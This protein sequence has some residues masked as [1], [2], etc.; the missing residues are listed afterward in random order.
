VAAVRPSRN[1][2][3]G[4]LRMT[5]DNRPR[6]RRSTRRAATGSS[7]ESSCRPGEPQRTLR[8]HY[9]EVAGE[10]A[11]CR[12]VRAGATSGEKVG[13][14]RPGRSQNRSSGPPG[15]LLPAPETSGATSSA[16]PAAIS[17]K[18][19]PPR[20]GSPNRE[21]Y[22]EA[23]VENPDVEDL[24]VRGLLNERDPTAIRRP[25]GGVGAARAKSELGRLVPGRARYQR[26]FER[27]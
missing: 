1:V 3:G 27:E 24:M 5:F 6:H 4:P 20:H 11:S 19:P 26:L 23:R 21:S 9:G 10:A 13:Q 12:E 22:S 8:L 7:A 18:T 25:R 16:S 17:R 15:S 2:A 14:H